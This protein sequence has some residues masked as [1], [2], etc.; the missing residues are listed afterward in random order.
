MKKTTK[1]LLTVLLTLAVLFGVF[2]VCAYAETIDPDDYVAYNESY[3]EETGIRH[4]V[5]VN[6]DLIVLKVHKC[7]KD[8]VAPDKYYTMYKCQACGK[9]MFEY[10]NGPVPDHTPKEVAAKAATC[11]Q[12]GYTAG[13]VCEICGKTLSGQN[14]IDKT[15]HKDANNDGYC[16]VCTAELRY[17][18][19]LCGEAH[20]GTFGGVVKFFHNIAYYLKSFFGF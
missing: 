20:E 8:P 13:T 16:D 15:G 3:C 9:A 10:Y 5:S 17:H 11:T 14:K 4:S 6:D 1:R 12:D 18:C 7:S 2:A 19:P